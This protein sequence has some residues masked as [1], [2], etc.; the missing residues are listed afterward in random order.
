MVHERTH[1]LEDALNELERT[2]REL[3]ALSVKDALTNVFNRRFFNQKIAEEWMRASRH[4]RAFALLMVDI[5]K[6]K[7]INDTHGHVGGDHVLAKVAA[8]LK[9]VVCRPGDT[10][11]R[12]GGEEFAVL[13]PDTGI[14]GAE[15]VAEVLV[16]RVAQ[17][18]ILFNEVTIPV[19]ISIGLAIC[20]IGELDTDLQSFIE[21]ADKALYHAKE[22]GRNRYVVSLDA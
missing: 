3:Q 16:Q 5:D 20:R 13:L 22:G 17:E 12:Y 14:P 2:N 8:V 1:E 19:T 18:K 9:N 4:G 21:R 7:A 10:I 6:F 11:S 15:K